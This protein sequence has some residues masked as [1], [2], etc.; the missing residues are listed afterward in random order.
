MTS[1]IAVIPPN[2]RKVYRRLK[3][4]HGSHTDRMPIPEPLWGAAAEQAREHGIFPIA[5][6]LHPEYGKFK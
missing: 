6:S 4:W 5:K 1:E 3:R 2:V